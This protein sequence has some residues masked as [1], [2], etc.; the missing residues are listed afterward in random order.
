MARWPRAWNLIHVA[1]STSRPLF[2]TSSVLLHL[3][4]IA[5][6]LST[7]ARAQTATILPSEASSSF[8]SCGLT[9]SLLEQA[10]DNCVPPIAPHTNHATYV[11]CFC[12][13]NLLVQ[14]HTSSNNICEDSCTSASDRS[15]IQAWYSKYCQSTGDLQETDSTVNTKR[16]TLDDAATASLFT[17]DSRSQKWWTTHYKWVIM[18]IVLVVAFSILT[19]VGIWLK[20]RHDRKYPGLYHAAAT[21]GTDSALLAA[22][23]QDASPSPGPGPP[24][25][26]AFRAGRFDPTINSGSIASSSHTNVAAPPPRPSRTPSRLQKAQPVD[27]GDIEIR[28]VPR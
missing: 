21:G 11:S 6:L 28:E 3:S 24:A 12:Q 22:R 8:P 19:A 13:S 9:C 2:S 20:R 14:L 18:I 1:S 25:Q 26:G 16:D 10:Q 4:L 23:Q 5:L 27:E 7:V 17:R 15:L